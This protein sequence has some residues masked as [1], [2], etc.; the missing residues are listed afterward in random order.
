MT[1]AEASSSAQLVA[2]LLRSRRERLTPRDVGLPTGNRRRTK[3]L[4][5]EEVAQL[6]NISATYYTFLEQGRDLHPS[7]RVLDSLASALRLDRAERSHLHQLAGGVRVEAAPETEDLAPGVAELVDHLDPRPT[8]VTGRYFDVLAANRAARSLWTD[9]SSLP[10][11]ERNLLWWTFTAPAARTVFVDWEAEASSLLVN[12]RIA[13]G[14]HPRDLR[15][16]VLVERLHAVSPEVR[17]WWPRHDIAGR[18]G[19]TVRLRHHELGVL[20]LRHTVLQVADELDQLVVTYDVG[21]HDRERVAALV[22][23]FSLGV[24]VRAD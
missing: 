20:D 21:E 13:A 2:E 24:V 5:R 19:D 11:A 15:F 9:W 23:D 16:G 3:G 8:Y 12:F 1:V 7:L 6:A 4:R 14:R 17:D 10:P 22:E 18:T